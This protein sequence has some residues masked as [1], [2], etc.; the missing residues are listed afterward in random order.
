MRRLNAETDR[1]DATGPATSVFLAGV[2]NPFSYYS[3]MKKTIPSLVLSLLLG[4]GAIAWG[5]IP[6]V[7][8]LVSDKGGKAAYKGAT[9]TSG[10]FATAK[11]Q[12]GNYVVQFNSSSAEL[13]GKQY[14]I[15]VSAGSKKVSANVAGDKFA[16]GGVAMKVD[17]G[18]GLNITGQV[19]AQTG[20][21]S[22][23]GKKMVWIPKQLGSNQPGHWVEEGSA[24]AIAAKNAGILTIEDVNKM[25]QH[26]SNPAGN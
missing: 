15:V 9:N 20:P 12:P 26:M 2:T 3:Q 5:G 6:P 16:G 23:G 4:A 24:E 17:V 25:Q 18:A 13:K 21:T 19:A 11:L 14:A 8:V 10:A 22:K 7:N 1:I